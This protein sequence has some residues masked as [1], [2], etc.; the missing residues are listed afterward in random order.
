M[1]RWQPDAAGRLQQAALELYAERGY[2]ETTVAEISQRA[3]LTERTFF[4]HFAD[5]R[6]VLFRG[7]EELQKL[8]VDAVEAAPASATPIE[9]IAVGLQAAGAI[10]DAERRPHS[11]KRQSVIDANPELHERELIKLASLAAALA[12]ALRRR[13]VQDPA[14]GLTADAGIAV[15]RVAFEHW[16]RDDSDQNFE[17]SVH[18]GIAELR[19]VA[20]G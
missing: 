12:D 17:D 8:I 15:F 14:A 9:A 13:G 6:E 4:R 3:G 19:T 5:K 20:A 10:F 18:D 2:E 11:L 16:L 1:G 7:S